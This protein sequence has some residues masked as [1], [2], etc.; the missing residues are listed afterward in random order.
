[1]ASETGKRMVNV[2]Q[3][4]WGVEV[5]IVLTPA[6]ANNLEFIRKHGPVPA[7]VF[8]WLA[9]LFGLSLYEYGWRVAEDLV[10]VPTEGGEEG[11]SGPPH[12]AR[13]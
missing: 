11:L 10:A 2:A 5:R 7:D 8:D 12:H 3:T 1:M 13:G 4:M 6:E 9:N